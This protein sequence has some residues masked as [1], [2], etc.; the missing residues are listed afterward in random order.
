MNTEL[1]EHKK[2]SKKG[3][4]FLGVRATDDKSKKGEN[5]QYEVELPDGSKQMIHFQNGDPIAINGVTDDAILTILQHRLKAQMVTS[6]HP[7][8]AGAYNAVT[9]AIRY[10]ESAQRTPDLIRKS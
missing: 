9:Q 4:E 1:S 8:D 2:V 6:G 7:D 3:N 10:R 5:H